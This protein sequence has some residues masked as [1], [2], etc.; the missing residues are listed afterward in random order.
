M[1][2]GDQG[3]AYAAVDPIVCLGCGACITSCPTGAINQHVQSDL[4]IINTLESLLA[5]TGKVGA[6]K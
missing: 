6:T 2:V 3:T 1:K 4:S 5:K